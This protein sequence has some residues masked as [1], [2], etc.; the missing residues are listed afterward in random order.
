MGSRF[1][2]IAFSLCIS[3][4]GSV[5]CSAQSSSLKA[6]LGLKS[7]AESTQ[8]EKNQAPQK[9]ST[10][11]RERMFPSRTSVIKQPSARPPEAIQPVGFNQPT[12][13][14]GPHIPD[15][16]VSTHLPFPASEGNP[17]VL[18][19]VSADLAAQTTRVY[20]ETS[21]KLTV[22][23]VK[24]TPNLPT[25]I[26]GDN[27]QSTATTVVTATGPS[28]ETLQ[29]L[30]PRDI[31]SAPVPALL[32][33]NKP[34][35]VQ[36][37]L[38]AN[39]TPA[40][41]TTGTTSAPINYLPSVKPLLDSQ[42]GVIGGMDSIQSATPRIHQPIAQPRN[43]PQLISEQAF[44]PQAQSQQ[45]LSQQPLSQQPL[46]QQPLSQQPLSQQPLSQQALSQQALNE[47]SPS[48]WVA[49]PSNVPSNE[50][51]RTADVELIPMKTSAVPLLASQTAADKTSYKIS[52][53][54][55]SYVLRAPEKK[56]D[57]VR[58]PIDVLPLNKLVATQPS[59]TEIDRTYTTENMVGPLANAATLLTQ[60]NVDNDFR[61][62]PSMPLAMVRT[63]ADASGYEPEWMQQSYA[64][65]A[66]TF[67]HKPLYFE[68]TNLERYGYGPKRCWQ[69]IAS[70]AHFFGSVGLFPYKLITQHPYEKVYTLGNNRPGDCVPYQKRTLLGQSYPGELCKYWE[71]GSGYN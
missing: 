46:S 43:T 24:V 48:D 47:H 45:P 61:Q 7:S 69:P 35:I 22:P 58:L 59:N 33:E 60:L 21:D 2:L 67:R 36:P 13:I 38:V 29:N 53:E 4:H 14:A 70:G 25:A 32:N 30:G 39:A 23:A 40:N 17:G 28:L 11:L 3:L 56:V 16:V 65:V 50:Q 62:L 6:R 54:P 52:D 20:Q 42:A 8:T 31:V 66:P 12:N 1:R 15:V 5:V 9:K 63:T 37:T 68:Q 71:E 10:A 34:V 26:T 18:S 57:S 51:K 49:G 64:W 19:P 55:Q 44:S 41:I 27:N